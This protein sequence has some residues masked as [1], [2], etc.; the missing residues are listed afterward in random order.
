MDVLQRLVEQRQGTGSKDMDKDKDMVRILDVGCASGGFLREA[1]ERFGNAL[2]VC[3]GVTGDAELGRE[4][5]S[6]VEKG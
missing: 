2:G 4:C 3:V 1:K 5:G 6:W